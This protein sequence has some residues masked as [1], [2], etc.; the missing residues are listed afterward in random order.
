MEPIVSAD[1]WYIVKGEHAKSGE[2]KHTV[3][4]FDRSSVE[5]LDA[6]CEIFV[7]NG[8]SSDLGF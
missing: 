7:L 4:V 8:V 6:I 2:A 5:N 1:N 3:K